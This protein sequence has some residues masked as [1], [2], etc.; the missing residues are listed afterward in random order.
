MATTFGSIVRLEFGVSI[1]EDGILAAMCSCG[2][3]RAF[4]IG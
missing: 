4:G 3:W 2:G 1:E